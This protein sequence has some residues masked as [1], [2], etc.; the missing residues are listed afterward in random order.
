MFLL[1]D[2]SPMAQE[3]FP[4]GGNDTCEVSGIYN[5]GVGKT[6]EVGS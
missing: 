5:E 2:V 4:A 6:V 1:P 3:G